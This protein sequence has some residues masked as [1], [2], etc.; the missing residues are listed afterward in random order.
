[1]FFKTNICCLLLLLIIVI[2][3]AC[4]GHIR[5]TNIYKYQFEGYEDNGVPDCIG[6]EDVPECY[7]THTNNN[8]Y[9]DK[10]VLKTQMVPPICPSCP[11]VIN[12]HGHG[13]SLYDGKTGDPDI[14][15]ESIIPDDS[16]NNIDI[17]SSNTNNTANTSSIINNTTTINENKG[18]NRIAQNNT[19]I[20]ESNTTCPPCPSCERCPE[21]AFSCEKVVNYCSSSAGQYLPIPV[22]NDFGSFSS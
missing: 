1:M 10:Y 9:D 3:F 7:S 16:T 8:I 22:L 6:G 21:P 11:S 5:E 15:T 12:D 4:I 19:E 17:N 13:G 2:T 18:A 14:P 20:A